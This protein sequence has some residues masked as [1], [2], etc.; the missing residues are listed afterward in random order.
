MSK[1]NKKKKVHKPAE[2][3]NDKKVLPQNIIQI[4]ERVL[5]NKNIYISQP[6]YK[7]IHKF[8]VNKTVDEAG[9]FL[10]G[11]TIDQFG[12]T[13]I[14]I[15]GFIEAKHCESTATTLKFTHETWEYCHKELEKHHNGYQIVGW[16]HTH[17]DFGIFLSEYDKF[18][19]NNFFKEES[20]IAYVIDPVQDAE[21]F[22]F[23]V[24][25]NIERCKGFYVF[26]KTGVKINAVIKTEDEAAEPESKA[27]SGFDIGSIL[28]AALLVLCLIL[29]FFILNLWGRVNTL[30]KNYNSIVSQMSEY[31]N[32]LQGRIAGLE[33]EL[34][35]TEVTT[36]NQ[37]QT[38]TTKPEESTSAEEPAVTTQPSSDTTASTSPGGD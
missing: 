32:E 37:T 10:V 21:G 15:S 4:G 28:T 27:K 31:L 33:G 25:G 2:I 8:T 7:E 23:W 12:K 26:D 17:P 5:E 35:T 24:N 30:D 13:N 22:Y 29:S 9:G 16:V 19:Q 1:K 36:T 3:E 34:Y 11:Y 20:Q 38:D 18:I 14:I 6:V